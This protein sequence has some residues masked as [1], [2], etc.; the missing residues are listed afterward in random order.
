MDGIQHD[1]TA[2]GDPARGRDHTFERS[3]WS[4][5]EPNPGVNPGSTQVSFEVPM[6]SKGLTAMDEMFLECQL[7]IRDATGAAVDRSNVRAALSSSVI[8]SLISRVSVSLNSIEVS[9]KGDDYCYSSFVKRILTQ[10]AGSLDCT[11]QRV[12]TV[13]GGTSVGPTS[14]Q[15]VDYADFGGTIP[16]VNIP[17]ANLA[18]AQQVFLEQIGTPFNGGVG[19]VIGAAPDDS[20]IGRLRDAI[21]QV[22]V[23]G[24]GAAA[25]PVCA[26]IDA[27]VVAAVAPVDPP[28][29]ANSRAILET[30]YD[31]ARGALN[32]AANNARAAGD[33]THNVNQILHRFPVIDVPADL[34]D[35]AVMTEWFQLFYQLVYADMKVYW[36]NEIAA[37]TTAVGESGTAGEGASA[38]LAFTSTGT[39]GNAAGFRDNT[40]ATDYGVG[41]SNAVLTPLNPTLLARTLWTQNRVANPITFLARLQSAAFTNA[42]LPP[43]VKIR[44]DLQ[45]EQKKGRQSVSGDAGLWPLQITFAGQPRL[46]FRRYFM[47]TEGMDVYNASLLERPIR[48]N[49]IQTNVN[50]FV[51]AAGQT[52]TGQ[53]L[54]SGVTPT[55][56]AVMVVPVSAYGGNQW[57]DPLASGPGATRT[58]A[59]TFATPVP[60]VERMQVQWGSENL[61]PEVKDNANW[62][63]LPFMYKLYTDNCV[64]PGGQ[65]A[66]SW[67]Q[68]QNYCVYIFTPQSSGRLGDYENDI[69]KRSSA[70]VTVTLG[71]APAVPQ[72]GIWSENQQVVVVSLSDTHFAIDASRQVTRGW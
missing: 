46:R 62:R 18:N 35:P 17:I 5:I 65:P 69:S 51:A 39:T 9:D 24:A 41:G 36:F 48:Y 15:L 13:V 32:I 47:T 54:C 34:T 33:P 25:S 4:Y 60:L 66:L 58:F 28:T 68:F 38:G 37:I 3:T 26:F 49:T 53:K 59:G 27:E 10:G 6:D 29:A 61:T 11:A 55:L 64:A 71:P 16:P 20:F 45:L 19:I 52:T 1:T 31:N 72:A 70:D 21:K 14:G 30:V 43:G 7:E 22:L 8:D 12:M 2:Y 40:P 57:L 23:H 42:L 63:E 44:I 56:I 67:Q 50:S